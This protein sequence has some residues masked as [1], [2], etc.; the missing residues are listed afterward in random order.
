MVSLT[1]AL[2]FSSNPKG[3]IFFICFCNILFIVT[4]VAQ[5]CYRGFIGVSLFILLT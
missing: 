3:D 4:V 1:V 2:C 5:F